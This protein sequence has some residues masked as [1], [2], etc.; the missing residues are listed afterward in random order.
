M[1][2]DERKKPMDP[3]LRD[4]MLRLM[5]GCVH[6]WGDFSD[7]GMTRHFCK[8]QGCGASWY[9]PSY[10]PRPAV[11]DGH[12]PTMEELCALVDKLWPADPTKKYPSQSIELW[13]SPNGE[14]VA[15][16]GDIPEFSDQAVA[17]TPRIA[18]ASVIDEAT[19]DV[20][21]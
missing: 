21:E 1:S 11:G 13:R 19:K 9:G 20:G 10:M 18:L 2:T 16:L 4:K 14:W 5:G 12:E 8:K 17:E 15:T 3:T 7:N 6:E